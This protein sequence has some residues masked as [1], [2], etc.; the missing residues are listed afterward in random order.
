[1]PEGWPCI[2]CPVVQRD[3]LAWPLSFLRR[4]LSGFLVWE[5]LGW[6]S[7]WNVGQRAPQGTGT[8]GSR[9]SRAR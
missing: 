3:Q 9:A 1:M 5:T 6:G 2:R 8:R 4:P 7:G